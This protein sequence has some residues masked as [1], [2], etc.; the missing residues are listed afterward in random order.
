M[1]NIQAV[2]NIPIGELLKNYGY[3]T[4]EQL[5]AAL[6]YQKQN[7]SKRL[8]DILIEL[9]FVTEYQKLLALGQK[10]DIPVIKLN[11]TAADLNTVKKYPRRWLLNII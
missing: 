4:E 2:K 5:S 8:G 9:G 11:S 3:I 6:E 7:R 10:L 1:K